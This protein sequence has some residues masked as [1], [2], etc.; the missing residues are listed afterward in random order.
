MGITTASTRTGNNAALHCH[1]VMRSVRLRKRKKLFDGDKRAR[2]ARWNQDEKV[3]KKIRMIGPTHIAE[4]LISEMYN[5]S[6]KVRTLFVERLRG[7]VPL[8]EKSTAVPNLQLLA[9][10][11]FRFDGAHKIDIAILDGTR[12]SCIACEAKLGN[13]RLGKR[14]FETRFLMPCTTSHQD[15][16]IAGSMTAILERKLPDVCLSAAIIANH[17]GIEYEVTSP[18][19]LIVRK[20]IH[21]SWQR[22]G[23]PSF[24]PACLHVSFEA[25]VEALGGKTP[26]NSLVDELL[27]F[28]YYETWMV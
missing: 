17:H 22:S 27:S 2:I 18:W 5:R 20:A 1:P 3:R 7:V 28:D 21:D 13:D 24:S 11:G 14:Q 4:H 16:R 6:A 26:F 25:I 8:S 23:L 10:A 15:A 9:C 19:V 12:F